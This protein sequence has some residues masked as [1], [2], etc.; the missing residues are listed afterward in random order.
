MYTP[1][2]WQEAIGNRAEFAEQRL[3]HGASVFAISLDS[4]VLLFSYRRQSTKLFEIYDRLAMGAIG[5]QADVEA[6]RTAAVEFASRE[7]YQ[8]SEKDVT[9]QRVVSTIATP[10]K[11]AFNDFRSAPFLMRALFAEVAGQPEQDAFYVVNYDGDY[12]FSNQF[13]TATGFG[14][15]SEDLKK[16]LDGIAAKTTVPNAIKKLET[17]WKDHALAHEIESES[18]EGLKW[19]AL[20]IERMTAK[21]ERFQSFSQP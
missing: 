1:F 13:A 19:E 5:Q 10:I 9:I 7:G 11:A 2:D 21:E 16:A 17:A 12:T 20:L 6:I 15:S 3:R 18:L 8:R 4:G 14:D